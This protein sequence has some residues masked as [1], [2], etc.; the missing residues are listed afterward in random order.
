VYCRCAS[1]ADR[2]ESIDSCQGKEFRISPVFSTNRFG[3]P[4]ICDYI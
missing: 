1:K 3:L 4:E 2:K